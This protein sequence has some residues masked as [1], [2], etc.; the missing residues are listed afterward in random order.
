[1]TAR[2]ET[3]TEAGVEAGAGAPWLAMVHGMTQDRRIFSAQVT[4]FKARYRLLLVDLPGHGLSAAVPGPYG[5]ADLAAH[6]GEAIRQAKVGRCHYWATHTGTSIGLL[7]AAREPDLFRSMVLEGAVLPG[8]AMPSVDTAIQRIREVA[9]RDGVAAARERWW[10]DGAWFAAMREHPE[11]CRAEAHRAMLRDF[12][13]EPW[14][15]EGGGTPVEPVDD[16]L[17][18][19]AIPVLLYNGE[20]DLPDFLEAAAFLEAR[21]PDARRESI[22][23]AGGFPA[24]EA[25]ELVN[26][27]VGAFLEAAHRRVG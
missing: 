18:A 25:P 13:G 10:H 26:P 8:H 2:F 7:L 17:P 16:L 22:P 4:A 9:R 14:L 24:W 1:M 6:V 15:H 5:H 3:I 19:I 20:R 23:G 21:L 12:S 27:L 11:A